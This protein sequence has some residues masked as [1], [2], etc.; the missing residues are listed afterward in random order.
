MPIIRKNIQELSPKTPKDLVQK[1]TTEIIEPKAFGQ[2]AIEEQEFPSGNLRVLVLWDDWHEL[3]SG[4]RTQIILKAY[5]AANRPETSDRIT[6]AS[7]LTFPEAYLAGTIPFQ[8]RPVV[9]DSDGVT[10]EDCVRA[11]LAEGASTL[12]NPE[13]PQLR[14]A[15]REAA[16][17]S[18]ERLVRRLPESQPVW[19]IEKDWLVDADG[20][21]IL[22]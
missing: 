1:L 6:L 19:T 17:Q 22:G 13:Y 8:V 2:P 16:Q 9:R 10:F 4:L 12:A 15:S 7:G 14:F 21:V 5:Q 3:N 11:M 18:I 20:E